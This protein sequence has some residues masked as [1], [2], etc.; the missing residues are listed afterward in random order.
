MLLGFGIFVALTTWLQTLLHPDGVS[1][2]TAGVLLVAM[3]A[4]G[5]VGCAALPQWV[6]DRGAERRYMGAVV[7]IT[8]AG[9]VT[10]APATGSALRAGARWSPSA[11]C[12]SPR[13]PSCSPPP[14]R[15]AGH[16]AGTAGAMI[17]TAGNLGGL[18]CAILTGALVHH[19]LIAFL[20]LALIA[21][22]GNT[23]RPAPRHPTRRPGD[24]RR[25]RGTEPS[26]QTRSS[27]ESSS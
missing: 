3:I 13:C 4:A 23:P 19:P 25:G 22:A 20:A 14:R 17:W 5:I 11:S 10:S 2:T 15:L 21:A 9:C 12:C 8:C 27:P 6:A 24:R 7:V 16:A 26:P 18:L 1:D